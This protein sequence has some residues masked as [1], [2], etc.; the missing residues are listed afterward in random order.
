MSDDVLTKEA[1][2]NDQ[3]VIG[4]QPRLLA[5]AKADQQREKTSVLL[6]WAGGF[7]GKPIIL[8]N[9]DGTIYVS[10]ASDSSDFK[11]T[12][13]GYGRLWGD[14]DVEIRRERVKTP[15]EFFDALVKDKQKLSRVVFAGHGSPTGE[16]GLSGTSG[17]GQAE[18]DEFVNA[19]KVEKIGG[20]EEMV[21]VIRSRLTQDAAFDICA[22]R[23]GQNLEF[24]QSLANLLDRPVHALS[25]YVVWLYEKTN[26]VAA[27]GRL[28]YR[29]PDNSESYELGARG[30][31][32]TVKELFE[33]VKRPDLVTVRPQRS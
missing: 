9:A 31:G 14:I 30:N 8:S 10:G 13:L 20:S 27:S 16:L 15:D 26:K 5:E 22:C 1:L 32:M 12:E 18:H 19:E 23:V 17:F 7:T 2:A 33:K 28:A 4:D 21:K 3:E 29:R 11:V 6:L 24:L 25:G